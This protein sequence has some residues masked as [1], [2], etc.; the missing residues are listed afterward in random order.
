MVDEVDSYQYDGYFR[1]SLENVIDYYF[2]FPYRNRCLVS[3]TIGVFSN[4]KIEDEPVINISFN[5]SQ[6]RNIALVHTNNVIK[7]AAKQ[8]EKTIHDYFYFNSH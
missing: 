1:E 2:E 3:A 8:I 5:R 4:K 6:R 7:T